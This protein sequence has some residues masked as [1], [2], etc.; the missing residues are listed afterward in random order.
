M[1]TYTLRFLAKRGAPMGIVEEMARYDSAKI[2]ATERDEDCEPGHVRQATFVGRF[3][4]T[5]ARWASFIVGATLVTATDPAGME[6][7][8]FPKAR[9]S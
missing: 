8:M 5:M 3:D 9:G 1:K 7:A 4:P 2:T 6:A